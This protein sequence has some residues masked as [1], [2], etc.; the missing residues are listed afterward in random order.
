VPIARLIDSNAGDI[1]TLG[2]TPGLSLGEKELG[3]ERNWGQ[4]R[5]SLQS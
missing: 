4:A 5:Q 1:G 3:S 2:L